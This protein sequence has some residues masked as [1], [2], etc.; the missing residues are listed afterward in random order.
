M[1]KHDKAM[2]HRGQG[3]CM[4]YFNNLSSLS[5]HLCRKH[6]LT[7]T[8]VSFMDQKSINTETQ[9]LSHENEI[10]EEVEEPDNIAVIDFKEQLRQLL[11]KV[12][13]THGYLDIIQEGFTDLLVGLCLTF[14]NKLKIVA[15]NLNKVQISTTRTELETVIQE[16]DS[17]K[18]ILKE[19]GNFQQQLKYLKNHMKFVEPIGRLISVRYESRVDKE[20]GKICQFPV[21]NTYQYIPIHQ[22]IR[23]IYGYMND[24]LKKQ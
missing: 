1:A 20:T 17:V 10:N 2:L 3:G 24:T 13:S 15:N 5:T 23:F 18:P 4:R 12:H 11:F 22:T 19:V 21:P 16:I 9:N 7:S 6:K 8:D 14:S